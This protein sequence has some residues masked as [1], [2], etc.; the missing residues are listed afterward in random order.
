MV[1]ERVGEPRS[2]SERRAA[3]GA[4]APSKKKRGCVTF[5]LCILTSRRTLRV[6]PESLW[7]AMNHPGNSKQET[8]RSTVSAAAALLF[9]PGFSGESYPTQGGLHRCAARADK[10]G[11]LPR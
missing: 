2:R 7:S 4:E 6:T 9:C 5:L 8:F 3:G 10:E 1:S 11:I